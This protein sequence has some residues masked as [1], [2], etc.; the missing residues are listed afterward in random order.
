MYVL[1]CPYSD[2]TMNT[3]CCV[4]RLRGM[5]ADPKMELETG[6]AL[7]S[8]LL[9]PMTWRPGKLVAERGLLFAYTTAGPVFSRVYVQ[10][11]ELD[12]WKLFFTTTLRIEINQFSIRIK[13]NTLVTFLGGIRI[14]SLVGFGAKQNILG[15]FACTTLN[16]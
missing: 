10:T 5:Q 1:Y 7:C 15:S 4:L 6:R 14:I 8:D 3:K 16:I 9:Y 2:N 11:P 13:K 12:M